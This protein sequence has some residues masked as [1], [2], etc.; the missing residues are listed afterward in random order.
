[1]LRSKSLV[2]FLVLHYILFPFKMN[3]KDT[4]GARKLKKQK[5]QRE[6]NN[7]TTKWERKPQNYIVESEQINLNTI[8]TDMQ[9]YTNS[10]IN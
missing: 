1:M 6:K 2:N 5:E 9:E 10:F 7:Y 4:A 3:N 8:W